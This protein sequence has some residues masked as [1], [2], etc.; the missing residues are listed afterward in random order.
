MSNIL[1][2]NVLN[3]RIVSITLDPAALGTATS[4]EETFTVNGVKV[5]DLV[6][7]NKPSATAGVG[8]VGARVS[9]ENTIG[10]TFMNATAA[11][12][13]PASETYSLIV[14]RPEGS[15]P[16]AAFI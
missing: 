11:T 2:G 16:A 8:I 12:V 5:G 1:T 3:A 15:P 13:N 14:F 10:I 7:I 6:F 4:A 9:A